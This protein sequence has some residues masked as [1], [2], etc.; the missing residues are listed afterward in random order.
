MGSPAYAGKS[1]FLSYIFAL[2]QDHPCLCGEKFVHAVS[3]PT[4]FL[5]GE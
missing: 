1:Q 5:I 3:P 4:I 2:L